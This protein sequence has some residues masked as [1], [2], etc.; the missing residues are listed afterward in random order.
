MTSPNTSGEHP[1]GNEPASGA[2]QSGAQAFAAAL[3]A[4]LAGDDDDKGS[5]ETAGDDGENG[6]PGEKPRKAKPESLEAIAQALGIEVSEL[7]SVKVPAGGGREAMT[8]GQLKDRFTEWDSLEAD[9]LAWSES[10][11]EQEGRLAQA[12]QELQELFSIIPRD[13]LLNP[14][15]LR[16]V[17]ARVAARNQAQAAQV[18]EAIPE[19]KDE[20]VQ[21]AARAELSTMLSGYGYTPAE[22]NAI[23]DPRLLKFLRDANRREQQVKAALAKV[24]P[25]QRKPS[26]PAPSGNGSGNVRRIEEASRPNPLKPTTARGRFLDELHKS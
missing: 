21:R 13:K 23:R 19:W 6:Q 26:T 20:A 4:E 1:E 7:Y 9:R 22:V 2:P 24:R 11:V 5:R 8:V 18:L 16:G 14:D 25:I 12:K 17:A 15:L 3:A 10:K